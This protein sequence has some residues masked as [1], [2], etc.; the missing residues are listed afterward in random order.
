MPATTRHSR[1]RKGSP[2]TVLFPAGRFAELGQL[3]GSPA[4][5]PGRG[6][7]RSAGSPWLLVS[8]G[9][10]DEIRH[11]LTREKT[12]VGRDSG[13]DVVLDGTTVS[14][15][16]AAVDM[17]AAGV[18]VRDLDSRNGVFVNGRFRRHAWLRDGDALQIG[19]VRLL[20]VHGEQHAAS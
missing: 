4:S 8:P 18:R 20:V 6:D 16:H 11:R 19:N 15:Q 7:A 12:V 5:S 3:L 14:R 1:E 2:C 10:G 17:L 9:S 13:C